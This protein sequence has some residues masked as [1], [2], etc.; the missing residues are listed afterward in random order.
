M[1]RIMIIRHA[2]KPTE[3]GTIRGVAEHGA[4]DRHALSVRGWQR[5]GALVR[6]FAPLGQTDTSEHIAPPR[7][8]FASAP[9]L[10]N[11]SSRSRQTVA[12]LADELGVPVA[13][14]LTKGDE[15]ALAEAVLS[16]PGPVLIA[17]HHK[18]IPRLARA[19]TGEQIDFP[20][21]WPAERFDLVWVLER[22]REGEWIFHQIPQ[23]LLPSD[24]D[25]GV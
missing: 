4:H 20:A 19:I 21:H 11:P 2:E 1:T 25:C 24:E 17:W 13:S 16:H 7:A 22:G 6:F 9:T 12:P 18:Q 14:D 5:A 15:L 8:I 10:E 3:D 23:R